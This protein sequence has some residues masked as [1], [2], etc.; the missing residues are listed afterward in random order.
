MIALELGQVLC[1]GTPDEG[2]TDPRVVSSYLGGDLAAINR[3]GVA[4]GGSKRTSGSRRAAKT[5]QAT[6]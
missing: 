1:E 5:G 3:S 6:R 4:A 2:T